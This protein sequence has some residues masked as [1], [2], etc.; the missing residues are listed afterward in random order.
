MA[1]SFNP[2]D[3]AFFEI[4][5]CLAAGLGNNPGQEFGNARIVPY[6]HDG[7]LFRI[8]FQHPAKVGERRLGSHGSVQLQLAF[9]TQFIPD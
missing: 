2:G 3:R 9:E 6:H 7:F 5:Q 4:D 8:L 1:E